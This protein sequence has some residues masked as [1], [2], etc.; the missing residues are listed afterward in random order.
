MY[1]NFHTISRTLCV[2]GQRV[3][4]DSVDLIDVDPNPELQP[5][6]NRRSMLAAWQH[7]GIT[8]AYFPQW[9]KKSPWNSI[10]Y[11][12]PIYVPVHFK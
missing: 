8:F 9:K 2:R 4:D 10:S 1:S 6:H 5:T 3:V 12:G 7:S 11:V